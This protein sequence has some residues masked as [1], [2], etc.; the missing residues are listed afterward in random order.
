MVIAAFSLCCGAHAGAFDFGFTGPGV[1]GSIDLTYGAATDS[2][3]SN[4]FVVTG[5][6]GIFSDSNIGILNAPIGM[7]EPRNFATPAPTNLLA[8]RASAGS[9]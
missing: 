8:R 1:S 6:S 4:A 3:C 5:I 7:I 2:T 9:R